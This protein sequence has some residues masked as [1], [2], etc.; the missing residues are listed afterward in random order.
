MTTDALF[1]RWADLW[2]AGM[3]EVW[4]GYT[5]AQD[6]ILAQGRALV[7]Q[8][9]AE[10]VHTEGHVR[11]LRY[12][13]LVERPLPVPVLCV[14]SLINHYYVMD[15]IPERSL[16]RSMLERGID[17]YML[18]WGIA[19]E[20]DRSITMDDFITE[21]LGRAIR[22]VREQS[23]QPAISLLGYCMGGLMS[24]LYSVLFPQ[25][26]ATLINLA[27]PINYHDDGIYSLWT[28]REWLNVDLMVDTLGNI[29]AELLNVTFKLVRPTD[30]IVRALDWWE[31]RDDPA[32]TRRFVAMQLWTN[33]PTPFPGEV[34]RKYIKEFYQ[35]NR[36]MRG[37]LTI[38]GQPVDLGRLA[39]PTLT[40]AARRDHIAPWRSV[41]ALHDLAGSAD[42][43]L[44]IIERGHIGMVMGSDA[45]RKLWPRLG[46]WLVARSGAR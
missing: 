24:S 22:V 29:P 3:R 12:T 15:L 18:D 17:V 6:T 1:D 35:E 42:K 33:D 16:V 41:A 46:D 40:I 30:E 13:P 26:V 32:F 27:G 38:A 36:L 34:F 7:G 28:R 31:H 8:T 39:L 4:T 19:T 45:P 11:V 37:D 5:T 9:P 21:R 20:A 44:L 2:G 10:V 23:G 43:E 25:D 14:P